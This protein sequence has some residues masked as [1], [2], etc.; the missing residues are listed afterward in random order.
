MLGFNR[1]FLLS[2]Q[3]MANQPSVLT[4]SLSL[5]IHLLKDRTALA[6]TLTDEQWLTLGKAL[7]Q[8]HE[9]D[10]PLS[11]QHRSGEKLI[12]LNGEK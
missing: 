6:M 10:V 4:I 9:I 2:K 1:L 3:S 12:R 5:C 11:I 8:V 7:K